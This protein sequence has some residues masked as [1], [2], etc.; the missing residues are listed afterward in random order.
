M[1]FRWMAHVAYGVAVLDLSALTGELIPKKPFSVGGEVMS[2]STLVGAA[3]DVIA[4]RPALPKDPD[5]GI[6]RLV[7]AAQASKVADGAS[8]RSLPPSAFWRSTILHR[9]LSPGRQAAIRFS[10]LGRARRGDA[11]VR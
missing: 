10:R 4:S 6:V 5:A 7:E 1:W 2:G 9:L 11:R 8:C 3:F